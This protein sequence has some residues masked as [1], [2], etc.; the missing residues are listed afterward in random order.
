MEIEPISFSNYS[1][2]LA[3][4]N[5]RGSQHRIQLL[6]VFFC[7]LIGLLMIENHKNVLFL[8]HCINWKKE[9]SRFFLSFWFKTKVLRIRNENITLWSDAESYFCCWREITS[10]FLC[11][12]ASL[13]R[14]T[15]RHF[16]PSLWVSGK[17]HKVQ[18]E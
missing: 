3:C 9:W 1:L 7:L 16:F 5:S 4:V 2:P 11:V 8:R 12:I 6:L 14:N 13:V 15:W 18:I 17:F 10:F